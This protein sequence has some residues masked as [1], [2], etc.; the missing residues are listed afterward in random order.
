MKQQVD[1][2]TDQ[3]LSSVISTGVVDLPAEQVS[4]AK[5]SFN[6][7]RVPFGAMRTLR[8]GP[9]RPRAGD[10]VLARVRELGQHTRLHLPS[11]RRATLSV[12]DEIA[13]VYGERYATNQF[14]AY[15][16]NDLGPCHLIAAGGLAGRVTSS[17]SKMKPATVIEPLGLIADADGRVLNLDRCRLRAGGGVVGAPPIIG[18]FGTSMDSG[19][20]TTVCGLVRGL[21][22]GG[23]RVGAIKVTGTG[24]SN[25][26]MQYRDSGAHEVLDFVDA[27]LPTTFRFGLDRLMSVYEDLVAECARQGCDAIVVE[28]ADGLHQD[29]TAAIGR[30][31][32]MRESLSSTVFACC[33]SMGALGGVAWLRSYGHDVRAVSGAVTASEL[34]AREAR[35][36][37]DVP[38]LGLSELGNAAQAL[39]LLQ[40]NRR[41]AV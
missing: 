20:T 6:T 41:R 23:L 26:L 36:V 4:R 28:V 2:Q 16:P 18:V 34:S 10:L 38:V 8:V 39:A 19:K 9:E 15:M 40:R 13:V 33:D 11:G 32:W 24:S 31:A 27:G 30:S 7:R 22:A 35:S 12:G 21:V 5:V 29:E 3:S 14:E 37:L 25:D 17:H 1:G